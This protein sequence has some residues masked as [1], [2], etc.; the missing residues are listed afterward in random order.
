[1]SEKL[2]RL[3]KNTKDLEPST[4]LEAFILSKIEVMERK[5][6]QRKLALSYAGIFSSAVA[7]VYFIMI[8]GSGIIESEFFNLLALA[9]S[10]LGTVLA[11]WK[12][13]SYSLMETFPVVYTAIIFVPVFTLLL[14]FNGY[15]NNHNHNRRYSAT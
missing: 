3:F 10:D 12:D 4:G 11:N 14:S 15:L 8:F 7:A 5:I 6:I 9:F 13:F 2:S 1:M